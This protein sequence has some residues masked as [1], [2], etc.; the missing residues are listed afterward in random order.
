MLP[1]LTEDATS[2]LQWLR[3]N[4]MPASAAVNSSTRHFSANG[5]APA[6]SAAASAG[7]QP[8]VQLPWTDDKFYLLMSKLVLTATSSPPE[9]VVDTVTASFA[10]AG[11]QSPSAAPPAVSA[12]GRST[13]GATA[14]GAKP[15]VG[16][17]TLPQNNDSAKFS[18]VDPELL[19][20]L[21]EWSSTK[22]KLALQQLLGQSGKH[23]AA[24]SLAPGIQAQA[25]LRNFKITSATARVVC[26]KLLT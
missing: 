23:S 8:A 2:M 16:W 3:Q 6:S 18:A 22:V 14:N 10:P 11:L 25:P 15:S 4:F 12:N 5:I 13:A 17:A 20:D 24:D 7:Q 19:C 1:L 9:A 21:L 26:R